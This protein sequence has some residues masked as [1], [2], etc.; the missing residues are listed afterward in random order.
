MG[1]GKQ[2]CMLYARRLAPGL[3]DIRK[4][5][6]SRFCS[7]NG[8]IGQNFEGPRG[9]LHA[10]RGCPTL[11]RGTQARIAIVSIHSKDG[12]MIGD[13]GT[14]SY[15]ISRGSNSKVRQSCRET[16]VDLSLDC[17]DYV[18][19]LVYRL[20]VLLGIDS[21]LWV[22]STC[23]VYVLVDCV[24]CSLDDALRGSSRQ[25]SGPNHSSSIMTHSRAKARG[26]VIRGYIMTHSRAKARG[27]STA[28]TLW[29]I[30]EPRLGAQL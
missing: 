23:V 24:S 28:V 20:L 27:P 6:R 29:P 14:C 7:R 18:Y 12:A 19:M 11:Y 22:A 21:Q 13:V 25:G 30:V 10:R 15:W 17:I 9:G 5:R 16:C 3:G 2:A 1:V 8:M 26:P 4:T